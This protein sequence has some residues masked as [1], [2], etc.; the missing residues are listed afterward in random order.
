M[1][2]VSRVGISAVHGG[3]HAKPETETAT[4]RYQ[5]ESP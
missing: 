2:G 4:D 5:Q 3:E 1:P